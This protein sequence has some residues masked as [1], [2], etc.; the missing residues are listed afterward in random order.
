MLPP[1][2]LPLRPRH[3]TNSVQWSLKDRLLL[4]WVE[5]LLLLASLL[6]PFARPPTTQQNLVASDC[7]CLTRCSY[8][9]KMV[10]CIQEY[11]MKK[12]RVF[13]NEEENFAEEE[14]ALSS[15]DV[16]KREEAKDV[17][18]EVPLIKLIC[19]LLLFVHTIGAL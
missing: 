6:T 7:D 18:P 9:F 3:E 1:L 19:L 17:T 12:K 8:Y 16:Q 4:A 2:S 13:F 10:S 15:Y 11:L 14:A 5:S